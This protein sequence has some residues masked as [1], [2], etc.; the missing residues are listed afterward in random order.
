MIYTG[1]WFWDGSTYLASAANF[2]SNPLWVSG[3]TSGCVTVPSGWTDWQIWQYSDGTCAGCPAAG[4]SVPGVS[5]SPSVDRDQFNGTLADLQNFANGGGPQWGAQF[6][7]Q[8]FPYASVGTV[9]IH[10]GDSAAVWLEMRNSGTQTWDSNTRLAT[11]QPRDHTD[12]FAGPDWL[13]PNRPA[14]VPSGT[15]VA[16]GSS[17]RFNWTWSVPVTTTPGMYTEWFGMVEEGTAWFSDPGQGG[18]PDNQLEAIIEVLP[19]V[20]TPDAGASDSGAASDASVTDASGSD[21]SA[22]DASGADAGATDARPSDASTDAR[23]DAS[24]DGGGGPLQGGCGCRI[25]AGSARG[26]TMPN[27]AWIA[28]G[29]VAVRRR[30]RARN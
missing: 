1:A 23:H 17:Y 15:T 19:P 6:V 24:R 4:T 7:M 3:Y 29:F 10:A 11:T 8:S 14:G 13:A 2:G 28:L 22:G 5:S 18:P 12:P 21:A 27:V 30:R 25:A 16:P 20:A 9:Q 26:S